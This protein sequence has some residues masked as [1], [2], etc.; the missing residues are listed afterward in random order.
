MSRVFGGPRPPMPHDRLMKYK[1]FDSIGASCQSFIP[2]LDGVLRGEVSY[3]I[4]VPIIKTFS[5]HIESSGSFMTGTSERDQ[6][7][8][9]CTLDRPV[10][11]T[12]L[13]ELGADAI[14]VSV[15]WFSQWR[16]GNVSRRWETFGWRDRTQTNFTLRLKSRFYH[17]E[18]RPVIDFL[19]NT[20][21]WGYGALVCRYLPSKHMR[22]ELGFLWFYAKNPEDS[23][24]AN[25]E[26]GDFMYFRIGYEF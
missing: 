13:Q 20:R 26:N 9:G 23:S 14:D 12:C 19:Y 21:N 4:G 2:S 16:L 6:L 11:I 17:S 8:V 18:F 10:I 25:N 1:F 5:R 24:V 22:Y 15:G 7:N 3:E